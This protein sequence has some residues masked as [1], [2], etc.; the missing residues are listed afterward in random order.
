MRVYKARGGR[1]A[2]G[3][4]ED[5]FVTLPRG[6]ADRVELKI[7]LAPKVF[8][9]LSTADRVGL[10]RAMLDGKIVAEAALQPVADVPL[11]GFFRRFWDTIVS[12]FH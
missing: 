6:Q 7:E 5:L 9:P 4:S 1:A 11:G 2:V 12:W 3:V 10:V 8:A